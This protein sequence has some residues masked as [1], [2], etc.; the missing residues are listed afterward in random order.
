[1]TFRT[2]NLRMQTTKL[3]PRNG[4]ELRPLCSDTIKMGFMCQRRAI[5]MMMMERSEPRSLS[6]FKCCSF[7]RVCKSFS[8]YAS[9]TIF[10]IRIASF[11]FNCIQ[12]ICPIMVWYRNSPHHPRR[13]FDEVNW[14]F[15]LASANKFIPFYSNPP[16]FSVNFWDAHPRR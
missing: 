12:K 1:M 14:C 9:T 7:V 15:N 8:R 11:W 2:A 6:H 16:A 5:L 13:T 10:A 3:Q 4:T